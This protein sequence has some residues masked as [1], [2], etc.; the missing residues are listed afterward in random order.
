MQKCEPQERVPWAPKFEER[1]QNETVRQERCARGAAWNLAKDVCELKKES[2]DTFYSPAKAWVMPAPSSKKPKE[3]CSVVIDSGASMHVSSKKDLSS[4]E[5]ETLKRSR[6]TITVVTANCEV[7][8][9]EEAQVYLHDL[10]IFVTV[11]LLQDTPAVLSLGKLCKELGYTYEWPS[12][13][14]PRLT[15]NGKQTFCKTENFVPLLV[16]GLSSSST[17]SHR[18]FL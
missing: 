13:R 6:T 18:Y 3:R 17:S 12:G 16:P 11:Q 7:Q 14:E 15:E 2:Q 4:R 8:T 5:L 9:N 10:H 1:T